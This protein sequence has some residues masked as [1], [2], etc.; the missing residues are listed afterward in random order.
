MNTYHMSEGDVINPTAF[1][2]GALC[3]GRSW[4]IREECERSISQN[5]FLS[6][7]FAL[8]PA[9]YNLSGLLGAFAKFRE[10]TLTLFVSVCLFVGMEHLASN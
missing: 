6:F 4:W 2:A 10:A 7:Y 1:T 3:V 5:H 9:V 8:D